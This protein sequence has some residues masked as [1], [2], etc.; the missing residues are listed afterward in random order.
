MK[1]ESSIFPVLIGPPV[2]KKFQIAFQSPIE[3]QLFPAFA[4]EWKSQNMEMVLGFGGLGNKFKARKLLRVSQEKK[5][6]ATLQ[7]LECEIGGE[8]LKE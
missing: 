6:K 8:G 1:S 2:T 4:L 3:H 7:S 5:I